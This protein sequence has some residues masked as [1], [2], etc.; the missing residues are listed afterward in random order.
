MATAKP[1]KPAAVSQ[2][3]TPVPQRSDRAN[4]AARADATLTTIPPM[5]TSLNTNLNYV[6]QAV[7]YIEEQSNSV[8]ASATSVAAGVTVVQQALAAIQSGPVSSVNGRSGVVTGLVE[9]SV[10]STKNKTNLMADAPLGQWASYNDSTG[11]GTDWPTSM[12]NGFWN[13]FT[14]GTATRKTQIANQ[15]FAGAQG[16][17]TFIRQLH[18]AAWSPWARVLT[19]RTVLANRVS[20]SATTSTTTIDPAEGSRQVLSLAANT[21]ITVAAP[22]SGGDELVLQ[23][24]TTG[25]YSYAFASAV[26]PKGVTSLPTIGTSELLTLTLL[27]NVAA[28]QWIVFIGVKH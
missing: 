28:T 12:T 13:V 2:I 19:D 22:R 5:V 7:N 17:W 11:A 3:A 23:I 1:T 27:P 18:D 9:T 24:Y 8:T 16:G 26:L 10:G 4:F 14:F 15:V 21:T 20:K 6:A 25:S